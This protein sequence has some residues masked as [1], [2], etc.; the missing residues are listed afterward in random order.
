MPHIIAHS[1]LRDRF[2]VES[3]IMA[4]EGIDN[5][6]YLDLYKEFAR[7]RRLK[8]TMTMCPSVFICYCSINSDIAMK[9]LNVLEQDGNKC[10]ISARNL[11]RRHRK[12]LEQYQ[13]SHKEL[14]FILVISSEDAMLATMSKTK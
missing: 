1:D 14:F 6:Y 12:L 3:H 2:H 7:E 5:N 4:L 13:K 10:W 8:N 11:P 9:V